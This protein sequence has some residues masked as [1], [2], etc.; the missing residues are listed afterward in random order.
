MAKYGGLYVITDG[1]EKTLTLY[2]NNLDTAGQ[3]QANHGRTMGKVP[4]I[5]GCPT[6]AA[7]ALSHTSMT[8]RLMV[9]VKQA[10]VIMRTSV[11][12]VKASLKVEYIDILG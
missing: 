9:G 12:C 3:L 6:S 8:V 10:A 11:L 1:Q 7:V 5:S 4:D 2:A